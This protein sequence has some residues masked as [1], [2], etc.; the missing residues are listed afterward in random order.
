MQAK[1]NELFKK[2]KKPTI[3]NITLPTI[4]NNASGFLLLL[5]YRNAEVLG[6]K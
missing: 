1:I 4:T 5:N 3:T 6:F 2:K